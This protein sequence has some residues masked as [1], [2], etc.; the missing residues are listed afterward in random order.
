MLKNYM[1]CIHSSLDTN[2][3]H[4]R[5]AENYCRYHLP[6]MFQSTCLTVL[7]LSR[8]TL[9]YPHV[10]SLGEG[11]LYSLQ[12]KCPNI[13][14]LSLVSCFSLKPIVLP[15][16]D[17]LNKFYVQFMSPFSFITIVQV[18]A[19]SL[20]VFH[21][22]VKISSSSLRTLFLFFTRMHEDSRTRVVFAPN[23]STYQCVGTT[24]K[25]FLNP[26]D[27][28]NL[29]ETKIGL[30]YHVK[31][32]NQPLTFINLR[33]RLKDFSNN[34]GLSLCIRDDD[35]DNNELYYLLCYIMHIFYPLQNLLHQGEGETLPSKVIEREQTPP[36]HHIKHV[37]LDMSKIKVRYE[38]LMKYIM[39]GLF[40][41]S[42][43]DTLTLLIPSRL[44]PMEND[45]IEELKNR[46]EGNCSCEIMDRCWIHFLKDF[47]V[48]VE[49]II[50]EKDELEFVFKFTWHQFH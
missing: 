2:K 14:E 18:I 16:L 32:I 30:A 39:N 45:I 50:C 41:M 33:D 11:K 4:L 8:C 43:P 34:I 36:L 23:L 38:Y 9:D 40:W 27:A 10:L 35:D 7:H 42:H 3:T 47:E 31:K 1:E 46:Q 21:F 48:C 49:N 5:N 37:L 20:Q 22:T 44:Q 26:S 15:K 29:L 28:P 19:P 13:R 24:F 17:R 12:D 25:P 6:Y